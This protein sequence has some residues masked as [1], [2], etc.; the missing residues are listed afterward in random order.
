MQSQKTI[1]GKIQ[2]LLLEQ[3]PMIY[4]YFYN[5]LAATASNVTR[6]RADRDRPPVP[7]QRIQGVRAVSGHRP[8]GPVPAPAR[9]GSDMA[10]FI[11]KRLGLALITLWILSLIVFFAGQVLPGDPAPRDPRAAGRPE[12]GQGSSTTSSAST[13][14]F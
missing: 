5:Y 4:P 11:A 3:T 7:V 14:R 2:N 12:R 10:V 8:A 13:G 9:G 6:R 1:A